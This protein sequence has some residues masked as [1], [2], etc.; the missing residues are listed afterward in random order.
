V[1]P[2]IPRPVRNFLPVFRPDCNSLCV[3]RATTPGAIPNPAEIPAPRLPASIRLAIQWTENH[4]MTPKAAPR[5]MTRDDAEVEFVTAMDEYKRR[6]GRMFPT[7][8]EVL[9]VLTDLGYRRPECSRPA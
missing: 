9:E 6:S 4:T 3:S 8:S 1:I 2:E 7:W 5:A